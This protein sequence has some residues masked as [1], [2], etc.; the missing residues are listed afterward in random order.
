M[1]HSLL[2]VPACAALLAVP[3][4]AAAHDGNRDGL[5]DRWERQHKLSLKVKQAN[6]DQDRDGLRN[7]LEHRYGTDP[8]NHDSDDDGLDDKREVVTAND[9]TKRDS[10]DDGVRDD[11]ENSGRIASFTGGVLTLTL[12]DG[13]SISAKVT[14]DTEIECESHSSKSSDDDDR[15]SSKGADDRRAHAS[16]DHD[17]DEGDDDERNCTTAD[18]VA[19]TFVH[20]AELKT[21][22][23]GAVFDEVELVK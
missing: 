11:D 7:K 5:P 16:R 15:H 21:T 17:D 19:G 8:R 9:P 1:R 23:A 4:T 6:R 3:A 13:S 2:L 14:P 12:A 18:L 22:A 20:E 10:D